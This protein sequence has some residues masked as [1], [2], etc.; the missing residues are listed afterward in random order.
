MQS[1]M[2][3]IQALQ[4]GQSSETDHMRG[5]HP[6]VRPPSDPRLEAKAEFAARILSLYDIHVLGMLGLDEV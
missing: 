5:D 2:G 4:V 6:P 1:D 3:N